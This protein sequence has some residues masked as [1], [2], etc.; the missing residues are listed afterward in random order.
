MLITLVAVFISV[1]LVAGVAMSSLMSSTSA[2]RKRLKAVTRAP[3]MSALPEVLQLAT[4]NAPRGGWQTATGLLGLSRKET[5]RLRLKMVR[6]GIDFAAAPFFYTFAERVLPLAAGAVPLYFMQP[7]M[8]YFAAAVAVLG[9]FFGPGLYVD[10]RLGV[11]RQ[12][13]ENGLPDALDL[14]VVCIEAGSGLDQ[15]IVKTSDELGVAYEKKVVSAGKSLFGVGR[16]PTPVAV[17][18]GN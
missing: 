2:E 4:D 3:D 16:T 1:A 7:Q 15:A 13:I 9:T 6:A 18:S 12:D 11:R 8:S 10:Y 17:S 5:E 14:M